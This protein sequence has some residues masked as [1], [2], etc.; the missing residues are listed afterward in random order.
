MIRLALI[1][2]AAMASGC[3]FAG[4]G[5]ARISLPGD[6]QNYTLVSLYAAFL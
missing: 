4:I 2:V 6:W 1:G 5:W 3:D